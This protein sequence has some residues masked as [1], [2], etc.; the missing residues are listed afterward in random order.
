M[1]T[2]DDVETVEQG[3]TEELH[4]LGCQHDGTDFSQTEEAQV[5]LDGTPTATPSSLAPL[6]THLGVSFDSFQPHQGRYFARMAELLTFHGIIA[7]GMPVDANT[8]AQHVRTFQQRED[9]E[10]D[11]IPGKNTLWALQFDWANAR[12]FQAVNPPADIFPGR[13]GINFFNGVRADVEPHYNAFRAAVLAQGGIITSA[14]ARRS[15]NAIVSPG[16]SPTSLHYAGVAL[17]FSTETGMLNGNVNTDPYLIE[18]VGK[19]WQVWGRSA[20]GTERLIRATIW[21]NGSITEQSV[22]TRVIDITALA[23]QHGFQ[24]IGRRDDF[25]G[26]YLSAEW[27]HWQCEPALVPYISQ[28]GTEILSFQDVTFAALSAA[29]NG[30]I[31]ENSRRIYKVNWF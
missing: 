12:N 3:Q 17:D 24:R 25:P 30:R 18:Q 21:R 6:L 1:D 31:L 14:G 20:Q 13:G 16:R 27:W 22:T 11:G 29:A 9:L 5:V 2:L 4:E 19:L 7:P 15:L 10:V 28:F 8:F 26:N 23:R